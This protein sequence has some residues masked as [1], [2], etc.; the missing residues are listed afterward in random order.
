LFLSRVELVLLVC[1]L[2]IT[3]RKM[4]TIGLLREIVAACD[5]LAKL[6]SSV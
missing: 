6:A 5:G 4:D 3:W 1:E 2:H